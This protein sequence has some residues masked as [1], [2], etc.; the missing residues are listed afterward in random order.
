MGL[1][2]TT[3][4]IFRLRNNIQESILAQIN[5]DRDYLMGFE[6]QKNV[7][8]QTAVIKTVKDLLKRIREVYVLLQLEKIVAAIDQLIHEIEAMESMLNNGT[9]IVPNDFYRITKVLFKLEDSLKTLHEHLMEIREVKLTPDYVKAAVKK[10]VQKDSAF[11][12][13]FDAIIKSA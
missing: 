10:M 12:D 5:R 11:H 1:F 7:K 4:N 13:E 9:K 8:G 3:I 2:K 6:A